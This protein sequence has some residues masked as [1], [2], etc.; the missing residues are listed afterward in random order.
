MSNACL[1]SSLS[2]LAV[3]AL[4]ASAC[5]SAGT[6]STDAKV[7]GTDY[8]ATGALPCTVRGHPHTS[9]CPMGVKRLGNQRAD[10]DVTLP[11]GSK[12]TLSFD[13]G[14]VTIDKAKVTTTRE[15]DNTIVTIDDGA[16][17]IRVPDVVIEGD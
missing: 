3:F 9:E 13:K 4:C 11:D 8:H 17:V 14:V 1:R 10:V 15:E 16:E 2:G 5:A 7:P 6:Q 12:R